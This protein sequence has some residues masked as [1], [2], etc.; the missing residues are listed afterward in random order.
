MATENA[1]WGEIHGELLK[2][3]GDAYA[4]QLMVVDHQNADRRRIRAHEV[5]PV[6]LLKSRKRRPTC[7]RYA[8][9]AGIISSTSVPAPRSLHT[10][11]CPP[12]PL[13]RSRIPLKPKCPGRPS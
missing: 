11:S 5:V 8:T 12:I 2:K 7:L 6:L 4:D 3:R 10:S 1:G 9:E 13:E